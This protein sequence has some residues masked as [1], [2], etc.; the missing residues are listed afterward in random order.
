MPQDSAIL[1][2]WSLPIGI[3]ANHMDM[4]KFASMDDAGFVAVCGELRRWIKEIS[5]AAMHDGRKER[6]ERDKR[7]TS[8]TPG[9]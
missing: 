5:R 8:A 1:P 3:H 6:D 7:R 9:R 4:T 2:G